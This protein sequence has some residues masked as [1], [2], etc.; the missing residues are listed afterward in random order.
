MIDGKE[1]SWRHIHG[2]YDYSC[3]NLT[4]KITRLTKRHI[5]LTSWSKMRVDLAEQTLSKD[6]E[7]AMEMIDELKGISAGTRV[8]NYKM[9]LL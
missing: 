5:W 2:V 3:R 9:L 4:A 1:V 7:N 8:S 6:V